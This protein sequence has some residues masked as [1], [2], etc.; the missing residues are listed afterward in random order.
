MSLTRAVVTVIGCAPAFAVIGGGLGYFLGTTM[1]GYYR[2]V[3]RGGHAPGFDPVQVGVGQ[4]VTQGTAA[5]VVIGLIIVGIVGWHH[6][7][8]S[9]SW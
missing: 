7:R 1:P 6:A 9:T 3:F 2:G 4:G 5:G 8:L